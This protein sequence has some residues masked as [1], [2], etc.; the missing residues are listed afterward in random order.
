[1]RERPGKRRVVTA[2]STANLD[3]VTAILRQRLR[4]LELAKAI[5]SILEEQE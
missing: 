5:G 1:M 3:G 4:L 2:A